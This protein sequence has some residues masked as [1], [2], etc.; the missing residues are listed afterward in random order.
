MCILNVLLG[1]RVEGGK[2]CGEGQMP[3]RGGR[4]VAEEGEAVMSAS[5]FRGS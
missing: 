4:I 5:L 1:R 3:T 2:A